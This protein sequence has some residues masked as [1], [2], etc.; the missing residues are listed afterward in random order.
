MSKIP[1][2]VMEAARNVAMQELFVLSGA[3]G[4]AAVTDG[5]IESI[6][7]AILAER[8]RCASVVRNVEGNTEGNWL[9][10]WI[11]GEYQ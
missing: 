10:G 9:A 4:T 1:A 2:D 7:R 6:A 3:Y 11:M 5:T 8:E